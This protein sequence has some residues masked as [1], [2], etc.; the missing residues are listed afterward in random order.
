[1]FSEVK[2]ILG[3]IKNGHVKALIDEFRRPPSSW[4]GF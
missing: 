1:M 4:N 2:A 3:R